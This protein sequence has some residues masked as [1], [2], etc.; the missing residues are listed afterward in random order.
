MYNNMIAIVF[1]PGRFG[2]L[3]HYEREAEA[4]IDYVRSARRSQPDQAIL[5]PG[6]AEQQFRAARAH[7]LPI[8]A[9]TVALLDEAARTINRLFAADV[10]PASS[11]IVE[12]AAAGAAR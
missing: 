5:V 6:E 8:D 2:A 12:P 9:G 11:L 10:P 7:A 4:F 1:D 3:E